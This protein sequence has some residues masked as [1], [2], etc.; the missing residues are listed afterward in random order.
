M[1]KSLS[2]ST[3]TSEGE[4][5]WLGWNTENQVDLQRTRLCTPDPLA[6]TARS[7]RESGPH[8]LGR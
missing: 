8:Q 1:W 3:A 4:S 7:L 2:S 5:E 6:H